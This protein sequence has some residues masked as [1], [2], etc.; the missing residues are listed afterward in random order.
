MAAR[1]TAPAGRGRNHVSELTELL[2]TPAP[3]LERVALAIARDAFPGLDD[4]HVFRELDRLSMPL[5]GDLYRGQSLGAAVAA[6]RGHLFEA[7]GFVGDTDTPDDPRNSY[8]NEV[9]RRRRGTAAALALLWAVVGGRVGLPAAVIAFPGRFLVRIGGPGG[10]FVDPF[11]DARSL[12][13]RGLE[14]LHQRLH[15]HHRIAEQYL[16]PASARDIAL[17]LLLDLKRAYQRRREHARAMVV[18]D[19]LVDLTKS[20]VHRRDRGLHAYALGAYQA[21]VDDL[22]SYLTDA[23]DAPDAARVRVLLDRAL[24]RGGKPS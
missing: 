16:A 18:C 13:R 12:D 9:L 24:A 8:L 14:Q 10:A 15:G 5:A 19:R 22:V 17:R 2:I 7:L 20:P 3:Q 23:S 21:A 4:R 11:E 1:P 6:M